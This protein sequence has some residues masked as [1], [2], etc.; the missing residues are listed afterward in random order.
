M[1]DGVITNDISFHNNNVSNLKNIEIKNNYDLRF[2][3]TKLIFKEHFFN[4]VKTDIEEELLNE[5]RQMSNAEVELKENE[6][7]SAIPHEIMNDLDNFF[8]S[9]WLKYWRIYV[10]IASTL[11]YVFIARSLIYIVSPQFALSKREQ[12]RVVRQ[13]SSEVKLLSFE[14]EESGG[15]IEM[16]PFKIERKASL[17]NFPSVLSLNKS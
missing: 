5:M 10:T 4:D 16:R 17:T 7:N 9:Y 11:I 3:N 13:R 1:K 15:K 2:L 6:Q 8:E 12:S 14:D